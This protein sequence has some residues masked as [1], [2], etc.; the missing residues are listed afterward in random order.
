MQDDST[1]RAVWDVLVRA[2]ESVAGRPVTVPLSAGTLLVADLGYES[3]NLIELSYVIETL[4]GLAEQSLDSALTVGSLGEVLEGVL[5]LLHDGAARIPS[6]EEEA[7]IIN[8]S[9]V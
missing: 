5:E 8:Q 1:D 2:V 7:L 4:F 9:G 6:P 3:L